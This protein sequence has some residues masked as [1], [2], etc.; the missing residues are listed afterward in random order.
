MGIETQTSKSW[1]IVEGAGA[2][3]Q[4]KFTPAVLDKLG[5]RDKRVI[6]DKN[7]TRLNDQGVEERGL[8]VVADAER[9][10]VNLKGLSENERKR[11]IGVVT[12][13]DH[14]GPISALVEAGARNLIVEKPLVNN[15]AEID[16]LK[17]LLRVN[18]EVKIGLT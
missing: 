1:V 5:P 12:T 11:F 3:L 15:T 17:E 18:P 2:V 6:I 16:V 10:P 7:L 13:P 9:L 8:R 14:L 4:E